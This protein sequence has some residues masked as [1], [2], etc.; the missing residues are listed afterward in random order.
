MGELDRPAAM[1]RLNFSKAG[2]LGR[3][4]FIARCQDIGGCFTISRLNWI[5]LFISLVPPTRSLSFDANASRH[6][7]PTLVENFSLLDQEAQSRELYHQNG[8][9]AVV[10]IFT[11]TGCPIVQKSIPKIKA[12]RDEFASKGV[13]FWLINPTPEDDTES[14]RD[15]ARQFGIDWPIL[16]D[17]S[18]SVARSLGVTR[19]AEAFCVNLKTRCLFYRGAIDDQLGYGTERKKVGH[20]YLRDALSNFLSGKKINPARTEVRGCRIQLH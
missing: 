3:L 1:R 8:A 5:F 20:A 19:T 15:E 14:I 6:Q 7:I 18:Q 9:R 13:I 4:H 11:T 16:L 2:A 10:L 12:L 17:R